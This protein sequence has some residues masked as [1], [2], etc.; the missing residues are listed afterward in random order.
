MCAHSAV[1]CWLFTVPTAFAGGLPYRV[2]IVG[3]FTGEEKAERVR[4]SQ[5]DP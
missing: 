3:V 1:V 5:V 4:H 2:R